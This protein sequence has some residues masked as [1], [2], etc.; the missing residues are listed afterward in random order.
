MV[1]PR[2]LRFGTPTRATTFARIRIEPFRIPPILRSRETESPIANHSSRQHYPRAARVLCRLRRPL[3]SVTATRRTKSFEATSSNRVFLVPS[4]ARVPPSIERFDFTC[5]VSEITCL[6]S[7]NVTALP[8]TSESLSVERSD[9]IRIGSE[10]VRREDHSAKYRRAY[11]VPLYASSVQVYSYCSRRHYRR[12]TARKHIA[13]AIARE[14][15]AS[16]GST[17]RV[18]RRSAGEQCGRVAERRRETR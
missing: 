3:R 1:P 14:A 18:S 10:R 12:C 15:V 7:A 2:P 9:R 6:F 11:S 4:N 16:E 5:P 8:A 17:T 13:C